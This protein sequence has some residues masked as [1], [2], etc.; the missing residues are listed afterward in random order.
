MKA[1]SNSFVIPDFL[2][3]THLID[4]LYNSCKDN[5]NGAVSLIYTLYSSVIFTLRILS[6]QKVISN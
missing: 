6:N 3:F 4:E 1:F 5:T 2:G